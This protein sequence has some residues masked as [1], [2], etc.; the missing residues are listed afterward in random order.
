MKTIDYSYFIERYNAGEMNDKEVSWFELELKDNPLLQKELILRKKTDA[1]LGKP[2]IINLRRKLATIEKSREERRIQA[3]RARAKGSV[4]K[5]AAVITGIVMI[6]GYSLFSS[7]NNTN[8]SQQSG[9]FEPYTLSIPRSLNTNDAEENFSL[10]VTSL[11]N[12][13]YEEAISYFTL[14]LEANPE[15]TQTKFYRGTSNYNL[16]NYSKAAPDF[17]AVKNDE[18]SLFRDDAQWLLAICYLRTNEN[19]KAKENLIEISN[20]ESSYRKEARKMLRKI[21]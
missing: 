5:Y 17:E 9:Y 11:N 16:Q 14:C 4:L 7:L 8:S 12:K 20:S 19:A 18:I 21:N 2:E 6:G 15:N 13:N 1:L 3:A 10:G